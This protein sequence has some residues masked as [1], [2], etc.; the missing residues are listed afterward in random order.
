[1]N[2]AKKFAHDYQLFDNFLNEISDNGFWLVGP[3]Q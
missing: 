3:E 1:M 2:S